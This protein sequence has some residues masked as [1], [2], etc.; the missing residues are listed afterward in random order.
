[1]ETPC[2]TIAVEGDF[3]YEVSK[4]K[5]VTI[6]FVTQL[7]TSNSRSIMKDGIVQSRLNHL[8]VWPWSCGNLGDSGIKCA[9]VKRRISKQ[10]LP[11]FNPII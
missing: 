6:E 3:V 4:L 9:S 8:I 11:D 7:T 1:M 2:I 5:I 10:I